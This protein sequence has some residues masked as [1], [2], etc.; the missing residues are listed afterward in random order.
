ML[1]PIISLKNLEIVYNLG[2]SNEYRAADG[3]TF[4]IYPEEY[5]IFFGPS[6]CGKSTLMY[7]ILGALPPTG[8]EILVAGKNPYKQ[9]ADEL[10]YYQR[11]TVGIIF[12]SFYLISSISVMDN[13]SLPQIFA[14]VPEKERNAHTMELLRR[15]GVDKQA[16]KLPLNLSGGQQQRVAVAR[17]L[18]G[19][20]KILLADEPVG[21]L[22]ST[23][24]DQVMG[25]LDDINKKEKKT[26]ILIT[27]DAKYLPYAHRVFY[28]SDGKCQRIVIN[29]EKEQIY[30]T[31]KR[32][33]V[34][35]IEKLAR[36][37]PYLSPEEL[38]VK[39][40]VNY[41]TQEFNFDQIERL[42]RGIRLAM[43]G[44]IDESG[45]FLFL[46]SP[47]EKG[48]AG[49]DE[50]R[51][52]DMA[53][54]TLKILNESRDVARYRRNIEQDWFF[55]KHAWLIQ[56]LRGNL[57]DGYTGQVRKEQIEPLELAISQRVI[58]EYKRD[59]FQKQIGLPIADGGAGFSSSDAGLLTRFLEKL[60]AQGTQ[61][62][63]A[64]H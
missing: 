15:F 63:S 46:A 32:A 34:T 45:F 4:D 62:E 52:R 3:V 56:R 49:F 59:D 35:E 33:I 12:Q 16:N 1:D 43:D 18:V 7:C 23:S 20:P 2:K 29:P 5:I 25:M 24:S 28:M 54:K 40:V 27:H 6:G 38:R 19:N 64:K 30:K 47:L 44:K 48:G 41:L 26:V 42:E 39:S 60:I 10:V 51:A 37:H 58:G 14:G 53:S 22:D 13:V 21:N 55:S 57:L 8:G 11:S 61:I 9:T 50:A 36:I 31:E 17:S